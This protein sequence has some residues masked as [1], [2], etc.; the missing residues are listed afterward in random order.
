[1]AELKLWGFGTVLLL[2]G[3]STG[4]VLSCKLEVAGDLWHCPD[5]ANMQARI[6]DGK[7][8]TVFDMQAVAIAKFRWHFIFC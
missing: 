5:C 7:R 3:R 8:Y 4:P 2:V 6:A 1:M